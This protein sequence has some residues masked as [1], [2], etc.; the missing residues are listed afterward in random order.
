[1]F[2]V[3]TV[4]LCLSWDLAPPP[5]SPVWES[6]GYNITQNWL[7][8]SS[9][10]DK[11]C[12][13]WREEGLKTLHFFLP[14]TTTTWKQ[15]QLPTCPG[16]PGYKGEG[17]C[18][19]TWL[20]N[21][22][23]WTWTGTWWREEVEGCGPSTA[24]NKDVHC[25]RGGVGEVWGLGKSWANALSMGPEDPPVKREQKYSWTRKTEGLGS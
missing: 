7:A 16:N 20:R 24:G 15:P 12:E 5:E 21:S 13:C 19:A 9:A 10:P 6:L 18:A 23:L 22:Q 11:K 8:D 1:M 25:G 17:N 2:Q 4:I 14:R 3:R